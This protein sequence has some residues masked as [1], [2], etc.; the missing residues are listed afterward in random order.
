MMVSGCVKYHKL[1]VN[2]PVMN[3]CMIRPPQKVLFNTTVFISREEQTS[4]ILT[5]TTYVP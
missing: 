2:I 5:G 4:I 3:M 1:Q